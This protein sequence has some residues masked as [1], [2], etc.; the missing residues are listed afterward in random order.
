[1]THPF[2]RWDLKSVCN[3]RDIG[4]YACEGGRVRYGK[5][6]R[7]DCMGAL[8][9]EEKEF[10]IER[11]LTDVIDLRS[12]KEWGERPNPFSES[13]KV[14]FH[15][16]A[17]PVIGDIAVNRFEDF[18]CMGQDYVWRVDNYG[19]YYVDIMN[20]IINSTG[21]LIFHCHAGKDRTGIVAALILLCLGVYERDVIADY[22]VSETYL[23]YQIEEEY[24]KYPDLPRYIWKSEPVSMEMFI[25]HLNEKYGGALAYLKSRGF[26]DEQYKKLREL[27]VEA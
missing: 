20:A 9:L 5:M 7:S 27:L 15:G 18:T 26:L 23:K 17:P 14:N 2:K 8:T 21:L 12:E 19:S 10:L 3:M 1:M 11:G 13:V 16:F 25:N 24:I 4:G 22:Q 6:L